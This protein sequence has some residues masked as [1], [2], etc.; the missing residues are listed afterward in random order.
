MNRVHCVT[1]KLSVISMR[2]AERAISDLFRVSPTRYKE[3]ATSN[4]SCPMCSGMFFTLKSFVSHLRVIHAKEK[5][6]SVLCGV[7]G[8]REVFRTFSAYNSHI[9]RHHRADMGINHSTDDHAPPTI[10]G[11]RLTESSS[12]EGQ[13][14][15]EVEEPDSQEDH[16]EL[17]CVPGSNLVVS[18]DVCANSDP[19]HTLAVAKMLLQLREGH[20]VSQVALTE[21]VSG[22]RVLCNLALQQMKTDMTKALNSTEG[23]IMADI[24][25]KD[26]DPFHNLDSNYLLEKYCVDHLGCMVSCNSYLLLNNLHYTSLFLCLSGSKRNF[27]W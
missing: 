18:K 16:E 11:C 25:V 7:H 21:V 14:A 19:D 13:H 26:Y 1:R 20:Q 8:C 10:V 12:T 4:F 5:S 23:D 24:D 6:F 2:S 27:V 17:A 22:C 15:M 9:Y 3:M